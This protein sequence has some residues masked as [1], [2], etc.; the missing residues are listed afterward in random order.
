MPY[1]SVNELPESVTNVLPEHAQHIYVEAFNNAWKQYENP[2]K[3]RTRENRETVAHKV[4]WN[5]VKQ[6]YEKDSQSDRWKKK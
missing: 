6:Q 2:K 3:R 5:A 4:A 1:Q